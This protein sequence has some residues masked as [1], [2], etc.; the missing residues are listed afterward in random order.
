MESW[1]KQTGVFCL[2]KTVCKAR[3]SIAKKILH[4]ILTLF[5]VKSTLPKVE[6]W[7][8]V[9]GENRTQHKDKKKIPQIT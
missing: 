5:L 7:F 2:T 9:R 4:F 8:N 3:G 6:N 1:N